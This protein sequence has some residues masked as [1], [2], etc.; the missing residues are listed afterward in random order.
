M[1]VGAVGL[2]GAHRAMI[3]VSCPDRPGLV[4]ALAQLLY[5]HGINILTADQYTDSS[6][7][8]IAS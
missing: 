8:G 5:G 2:G 1:T 4:A 6:T 3:L 7:A